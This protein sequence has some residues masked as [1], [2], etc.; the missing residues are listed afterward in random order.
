MRSSDRWPH[1][2][3]SLNCKARPDREAKAGFT[4]VEMALATT[5]LMVGIMA[6]SA[7]TLR[8]HQLGRQTREHTLAP[9]AMTQMGERLNSASAIAAMTP[10]TWAFELQEAYSSGGSVGDDFHVEGLTPL[11]GFENAG[12][13]EFITNETLTDAE[14]GVVLG[15][16]RDLNGDGDATDVD[17]TDSAKLLP[18]MVTIGWTVRGSETSIKHPLFLM[19]Y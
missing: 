18:V 2:R 1:G 11:D 13:I 9:N 6:I 15:M 12:S 10:S 16:P 7:A 17:I 4:V 5:M 8:M 14:L 19:G 3:K